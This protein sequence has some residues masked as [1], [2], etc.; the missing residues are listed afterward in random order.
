MVKSGFFQKKDEFILSVIMVFIVS[1]LIY[2]G[3][4]ALCN[5]PANHAIFQRK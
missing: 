1:G 5:A 2:Q 4:F 3:V